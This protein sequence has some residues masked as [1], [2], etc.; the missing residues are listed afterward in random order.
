LGNGIY[1]FPWG[2]V[3]F[4]FLP[5]WRA[6]FHFSPN[7]LGKVGMPAGGI[8]FVIEQKESKNQF[9][10]NC[11]SLKDLFLLFFV[12]GTSPHYL[13]AAARICVVLN[14]FFWVCTL[15]ICFSKYRITILFALP[16]DTTTTDNP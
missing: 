13:P 12:R 2:V 16:Q 6:L 8:L 14:S 5:A 7:G 9:K 10:R 4:L 11:V 15:E 1:F 3:C